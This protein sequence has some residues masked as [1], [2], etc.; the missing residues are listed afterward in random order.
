MKV[1]ILTDYPSIAVQSGP[2]L[3][4][5]FLYEGLS[6]RNHEVT[7][8]GPDTGDEMPIDLRTFLV[9]GKPFPA[10]P[11][12]KVMVPG[13][14]GRLA[15][16][17][18]LDVIHGQIANHAMEY[19]GWVR[20]FERTA[21]LNTHIL[22]LP[23]HVHFLV[24][25]ALYANP[26]VR[27]IL[28][29]SA[30]DLE[31]E[32]ARMYNLGDC[33]IVQS[34]HMVSYWRDRGVTVPIEIVGRPIDPR[35]FSR[36]A[37]ADPFP[38]HLPQGSRLLV[39]SRQDRE[40][41]LEEL[42]AIFDE[43]IAEGNDEATLTLVGYGH[44]HSDLVQLAA[45][46]RH[47]DRIFFAGEVPHDRLLDW[48][49]HADVF[50]HTS[51][52][53]TFGNVINEALWTGLPVVALADGR[54]VSHQI[55]D[56]VNGYLIEPGRIDTETRF[57]RATLNLISHRELRRQLGEGAATLSRQ[58][59]HPDV[60]LSRF[61]TIYEAAIRR[62]HTEV[63]E[64]LNQRS[65]FTQR[66]TLAKA[67][68]TWARWNYAPFALDAVMRSLGLARPIPTAAQSAELPAAQRMPAPY[69]SLRMAAE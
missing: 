50:V 35:K 28:E 13:P 3:H 7:L 49:A 29:K 41:N 9:P 14:I 31:R 45:E 23:D 20:R 48:Y 53:E 62:V 11:K 66:A 26:L 68:S 19:A 8:I 17:P 4:T 38:A 56:G 32:C 44:T 40:K 6:E 36:P 51:L 5:R 46:A 43:H 24:G 67:W 34:R 25:D 2:S 58:V 55:V 30:A 63:T 16:P 12:V 42:I 59:S 22:H 18:R 37:G 65:A 10:H 52:S 54:G 57:A 1:G 27:A 60:V 61:E 47:G 64:P 15:A 21:V 39:V 69:T 33:L